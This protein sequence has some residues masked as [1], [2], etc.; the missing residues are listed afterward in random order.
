[1]IP[2]VPFVDENISLVTE[3]E[4][5]VK[6]KHTQ[7]FSIEKLTELVH[8]RSQFGNKMVHDSVREKIYTYII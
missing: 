4:K 8:W 3:R 7:F 1:M 6:K 2:H 5:R